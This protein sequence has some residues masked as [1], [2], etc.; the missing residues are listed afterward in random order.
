L[1]QQQQRVDLLLD[2]QN[3]NVTRLSEQVK[4]NRVTFHRLIDAVSYLPKQELK[5]RGHDEF[6][7]SLH[8]GNSVEF[9]SVSKKYDPLLENPLNSAS[10]FRGISAIIQNDPTKTVS[11]HQRRN[12]K[13][14]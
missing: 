8:R 5:F 2:A 11:C 7:K 10:V 3:R 14:N 6:S 12:E 13:R 4:R 1:W 9:L